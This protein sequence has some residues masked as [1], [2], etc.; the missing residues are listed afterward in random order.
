MENKEYIGHG[1]KHDQWDIIDVVLNMEEALKFCFSYEGKRY[2]KCS[3]AARR[4]K[5]EFG[6]THSVYVRPRADK[7]EPEQ[8][9][10]PKARRKKA[11]QA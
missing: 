5:T 8:A 11:A 4:A 10:K 6:S 9:P 7:P 1:K 3:V 2:L